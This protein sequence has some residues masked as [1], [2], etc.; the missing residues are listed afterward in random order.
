MY[1]SEKIR[2]LIDELKANGW[3]GKRIEKNV[4]EIDE[5]SMP[6]SMGRWFRLFKISLNYYKYYQLILK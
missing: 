1:S 4:N 3:S 2:L 6:D 5:S